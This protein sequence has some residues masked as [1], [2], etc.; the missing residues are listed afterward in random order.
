MKSKNNLEK[1]QELIK[2]FEDKNIDFKVKGKYFVFKGKKIN[3]KFFYTSYFNNFKA[4][5]HTKIKYIIQAQFDVVGYKRRWLTD[6]GLPN[7]NL[8]PNT[9]IGLSIVFSHLPLIFRR[10]FGIEKKDKCKELNQRF[11][12]YFLDFHRQNSNIPVGKQLIRNFVFLLI[13][14]KEFVSEFIKNKKEAK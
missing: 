9:I 8:I 5:N 14:D 2:F 12:E 7:S 10:A 4:W 11:L 13:N 6:E 1:N 3:S